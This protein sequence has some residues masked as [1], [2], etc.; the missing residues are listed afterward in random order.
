MKKLIALLLAAVMVVGLAA[1]AAAP[2]EAP[3]VNEPATDA[4]AVE[5][6]V[7]A[8]AAEGSVYWLNFK[9]ES[10]EAL[11]EIAAMYTEQTGVPV[12][13]VTAASGTYNETLTAQMDKSDAPTLF[14]VGN[15]AAVETW[16]DYC[17][18]LTGTD[19]A[20]ELSTDAYMLY[21]EDGKLCS[22]GYCYECYG[23][24]VNKELLAK[25]G[26]AEDYIV[27]FETLKEVAEDVHA[28]ADELGFDAFSSAGMD[29]SSSWRFTGH[30]IN[31][32]YYYE[33]VDA[34][35]AWTSCPPTIEGTYMD[36]Y[37]NL[38]D[39]MVVNSA[40]DRADLANG[41]FDAAAEFANGEALFYFN[42]NWEWSGLSEKG[43]KAEN[44]SM[45]P[46]YCGVEGEEKAG[47]N[48]GTENYWAVN[49]EASEEDIAAT[50]EFMK[51]LVTDPEA[52]EKAVATFGVMPYK[53]AAQSTNPF[54]A[55]ANAYLADGCYN[56]WWATNYQPN[57]DAYRATVVSALNAYNADPTDANWET[58]VTAFVDGWAVQYQA[59]FG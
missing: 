2:T 58:V 44:L 7:E 36:N 41:G 9:P 34:P 57:V 55:Q 1:C 21:D 37:R 20:N 30:L 47:L 56:M 13:V 54:L 38:Y 53:Q 17:L 3:V 6:P 12:K 26:Y 45:I 50:L 24:I 22:I 10:D 43:M 8:P 31:L 18:D 52:S 51:W 4:P 35:E 11:Q 19:I 27:N 29:S 33:S 40:T 46:Y 39:L 59:A 28:R 14:V 42:G 15:S 32:D 49:S 23:I 48:C 16:G 5:E 25:A